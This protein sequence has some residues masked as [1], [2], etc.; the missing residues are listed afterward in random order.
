MCL[1]NDSKSF[2]KKY[3]PEG[4]IPLWA[5]L[6]DAHHA[7]SVLNVINDS[8]KFST[9]I[10][11]PTVAADDPAYMTGYWRGPVWLDQAYFAIQGLKKYQYDIRAAK[12]SDMLI[13]R[14]DGFINSP[15]PIRE[16]YDPRNGEGLKVNNFSWS[17]VHL[18]LL[19]REE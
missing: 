13:N 19:L 8:T 12:Y 7:E 10:P 18:L 5:G 16:N 2:I 15:L 14:I 1:H 17:A 9:F 3:G 6:A 4:W 11:F